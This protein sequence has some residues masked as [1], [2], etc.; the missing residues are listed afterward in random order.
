MYV[1]PDGF[2]ATRSRVVSFDRPYG[3]RGA[4]ELLTSLPFVVLAE[5][6][7]STSRMPPTWILHARPNLVRTIGH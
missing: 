6:Q 3:G 7:A 4:A 1:G 2:F 5:K